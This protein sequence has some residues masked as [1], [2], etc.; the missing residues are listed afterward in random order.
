MISRIISAG[1]NWSI[2]RT[3]TRKN[4]TWRLTYD[5]G[6]LTIGPYRKGKRIVAYSTMNGIMIPGEFI[7]DASI[8]IL[9]NGSIIVYAEM[10]TSTHIV[11]ENV[12]EAL[13]DA[14]EKFNKSCAIINEIRKHSSAINHYV[15][16]SNLVLSQT[17]TSGSRRQ[18]F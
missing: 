3:S 9:E 6:Q 16:D 2:T 7:E 15:S 10:C 12:T 14:I 11:S 1:N 8:E 17:Q 5:R 13:V 18:S 4:V